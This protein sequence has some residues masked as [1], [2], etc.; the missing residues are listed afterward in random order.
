MIMKKLFLAAVLMLAPLICFG[1]T[2]GQS[3]RAYDGIITNGTLARD[4]SV[5]GSLP[6]LTNVVQLL[7]GSGVTGSSFIVRDTNGVARFFVTGRTMTIADTNQVRIRIDTA[8]KQDTGTGLTGVMEFFGGAGGLIAWMDTNSIFLGTD[9]GLTLTRPLSS[10]IYTLGNGA[11]DTS[12]FTSSS[13]IFSLGRQPLQNSTLVG[14][15]SIYTLGV[16]V[17]GGSWIFS[18]WAIVRSMGRSSA[19]RASFM[20]TGIRPVRTRQS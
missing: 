17:L 20:A 6:T 3:V 8:G 4:V 9:N 12:T 16:G 5:V 2:Q 13:N 14:S 19:G 11:F 10:E 7:M 18:R 15:R 1:A